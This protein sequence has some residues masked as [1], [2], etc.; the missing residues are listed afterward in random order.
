MPM[1]VVMHHYLLELVL[2][3]E[4]LILTTKS[5]RSVKSIIIILSGILFGKLILSLVIMFRSTA[6][7]CIVWYN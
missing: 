3:F 1:E 4:M 5:I 6:Y 2:L 7:I